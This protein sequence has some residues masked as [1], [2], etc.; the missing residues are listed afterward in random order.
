MV[1]QD[2]LRNNRS[3][4]SRSNPIRFCKLQGA[5]NDFVLL[6]GLQQPLPEGELTAWTRRL[7]DRRYG[8]GADGVLLVL[9]SQVADYRMRILNADGSEASM[10]GNGIRCFARYLHEYHCPQASSVSIE[11]GAGVRQVHRV[12]E[13][14][15]TVAMG[16]PRLIP[17]P[18]FTVLDTGAL[19]VVLFVDDVDS[20]PLETQ[21][22]A[23]EH[24][25][26]FPD[27]VNVSAAQAVRP[28]LAR[29]RV[30]ERGAGATL[31]CGTG[32]CAVTVAGAMQGLLQRDVTIQMPGGDLQVEWRED[33]TLWLTGEAELVFEGVWRL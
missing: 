10:C 9:P 19:H 33:D 11:T 23:I 1:P 13:N 27:R 5:G 7:C 2:D 17:D 25:P 31:A 8:V 20:F 4:T 21:G 3:R 18:E 32:A 26:R 12:A 24:H 14:R 28:D 16:Q 29:A 15:F 6:D 30:W 22:R